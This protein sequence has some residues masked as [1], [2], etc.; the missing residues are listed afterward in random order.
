M[1]SCTTHVFKA[2]QPCHSEIKCFTIYIET[3]WHFSADCRDCAF[4][5]IVHCKEDDRFS[6]RSKMYNPTFYPFSIW[7]PYRPNISWVLVTSPNLVFYS[8]CWLQ[9]IKLA[10]SSLS[11]IYLMRFNVFHPI[12]VPPF[13]QN[14]Y[15]NYKIYFFFQIA[16]KYC[17]K[18]KCAIYGPKII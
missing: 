11:L 16:M 15:W 12:Y 5:C 7:Y 18:V 9:K 17:E 10:F 6:A 4:Y 2:K 3:T 13:L 14:Y 8:G 1:L